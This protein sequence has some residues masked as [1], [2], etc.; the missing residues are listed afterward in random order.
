MY[1]PRPVLPA[2]LL[3]IAILTLLVAVGCD[4]SEEGRA[5]EAPITG[6]NTTTIG[7]GGSTFIAPLMARWVGSYGQAHPV[8]VNYR[9]I[10]SGAGIEEMK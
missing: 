7:A 4:F 10:G 9:A 1:K 6:S 5:K 3:S 8:H 2:V